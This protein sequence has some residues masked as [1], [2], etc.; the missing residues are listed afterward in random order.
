MDDPGRMMLHWLVLLL[1]L[2][3]RHRLPAIQHCAFFS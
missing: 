3:V 2:M 1:L